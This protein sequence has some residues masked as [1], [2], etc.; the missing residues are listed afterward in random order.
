MA[1]SISVD[2][3]EVREL[4]V[5]MTR[6]DGRLTRHL[7]PV[8]KK[9]AQN[10]KDQ[11]VAEMQGSRHFA[12]VARGITYDIKGDGFEAEIGPEK[13]RPGSLANIAYFGSSRGGGT[14][15]DPQ[16][17][18]DAEMPNFEKALAEVAEGLIFE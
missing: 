8:V 18:G 15:P 12:P 2:M 6:V 9:G 10:I 11:L 1:D 17:A 5:D 7:A 3:S 16:G 14:V 4:A 13:G